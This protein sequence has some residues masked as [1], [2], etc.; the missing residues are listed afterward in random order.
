MK[1]QKSK[2]AHLNELE[3]LLP[4][5]SQSPSGQA[6]EPINLI[7]IGNR[8][9]INR[10]FQKHGWFRANKLGA[11]SLSKALI[12]GIFNKSY[13]KGPMSSSYL[14]GQPFEL[15]FQHPTKSD[16]YR[17]RHHLRLWWTPY[18]LMGRR[19]WA[20]TL[21]YDKSVGLSESH[22]PTHHIAPTLSWEAEFL[23]HSFGIKSPK[24][25]KLS[26][27]GKGE[28]N[29]GDKYIYD[30]RALILDLSGI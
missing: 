25:L 4:K 16:T 22:I 15:G 24:Y 13:P 17:R 9:F 5:Y 28:L 18:K 10:H 3:T 2:L 12:A 14:R 6:M 19:I 23:A 8:R 30:G 1:K 20:G 21:S 29:I 11:I 26:I 27:G 7:I